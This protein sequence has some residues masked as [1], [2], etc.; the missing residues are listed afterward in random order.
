[1]SVATANHADRDHRQEPSRIWVLLH[2]LAYSG[3]HINPTGLVAV[4]RLARIREEQQ[5]GRR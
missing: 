5:P 3:A 1:M 4:Q 2:A